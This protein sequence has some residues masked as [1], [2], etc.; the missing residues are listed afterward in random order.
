[1]KETETETDRLMDKWGKVLKLDEYKT[2]PP[3]SARKVTAI[4]LESQESWVR[5]DEPKSYSDKAIL[6][7]SQDTWVV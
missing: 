4:L 2:L 5:P 1:M 7:E 6:I 3:L